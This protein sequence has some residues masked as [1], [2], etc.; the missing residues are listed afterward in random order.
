MFEVF[1]ISNQDNL[2][3][4]VRKIRSKVFVEEQGVSIL[5]EYDQFESSAKH[6]LIIK[7]GI[8]CGT[9]RW[10]MT[11]MGIKLE[12]FAVLK[13]FR[14]QN[15]G[16]YLVE[17]VIKDVNSLGKIIYL[18]AQIQVVEFYYKLHFIKEGNLFEEAGIKHYKMV[19]KF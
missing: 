3:S 17:E 13:S 6:Y 18:H 15:I 8:S 2:F 11:N 9:A 14:G 4:E 1:R 12:R 10:R 19:F 5:D 16:R 7:E